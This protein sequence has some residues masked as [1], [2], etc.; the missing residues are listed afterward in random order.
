MSASGTEERQGLDRCPWRGTVQSLDKAPD[1]GQA[2][3]RVPPVGARQRLGPARESIAALLDRT[4][5][6]SW[7]PDDQTSPDLA[8]LSEHETPE[9]DRSNREAGRRGDKAVLALPP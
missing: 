2:P 5:V 9:E 1:A 8:K 6:V 4:L 7:V 3:H